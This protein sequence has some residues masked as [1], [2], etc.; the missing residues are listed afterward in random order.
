MPGPPAEEELTI[1]GPGTTLTPDASHGQRS[2]RLDDGGEGTLVSVAPDVPA[3]DAQELP[4]RADAGDLRQRCEQQVD[5]VGG[6]N[7]EQADPVLACQVGP[8]IGEGVHE[9]GPS[10]DVE[11]QVGDAR[12]WPWSV[13]VSVGCRWTGIGVRQLRSMGEMVKVFIMAPRGEGRARRPS[14]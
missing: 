14:A 9:A 2:L 8:Q 1:G 7:A 4:V 11:E 5:A 3:D 13:G 6:T 12:R 10:F